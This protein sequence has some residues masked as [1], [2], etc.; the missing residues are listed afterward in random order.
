METIR[1][2]DCAKCPACDYTVKLRTKDQR[3]SVHNLEL[4]GITRVDD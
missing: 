1:L 2:G 4:V 3:C